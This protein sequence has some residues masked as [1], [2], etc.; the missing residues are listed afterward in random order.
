MKFS[1]PL[2]QLAFLFCLSIFSPCLSA[3]LLITYTSGNMLWKE[4]QSDYINSGEYWDSSYFAN[5][6]VKFEV[7]FITPDFELDTGE[8]QYLTFYDPVVSFSSSHFFESYTIDGSGYFSLEL[9]GDNSFRNWF[10]SL[11]VTENN[12][13][14]GIKEYGIFSAGGWLDSMAGGGAARE[15]L[16]YTKKDWS[17]THHNLL[18]EADTIATFGGESFDGKLTIKQISLPEPVTPLLLLTGLFSIALLK[19]KQ[20]NNHRT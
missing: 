15:Q 20:G 17:F 13:A 2:I 16:I 11:G 1:K 7:S 9:A 4:E 8:W 19:N 10:F 5:D 6:E 3:H 14:S 12:N 18:W